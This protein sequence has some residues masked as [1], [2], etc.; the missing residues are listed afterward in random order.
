MAAGRPCQAGHPEEVQVGLVVAE[1]EDS[2]EVVEV[3]AE[4]VAAD[5]GKFVYEQLNRIFGAAVSTGS[6]F[7]KC[8]D[9]VLP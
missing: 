5:R 7:T 6:R 1:A 3:L 8:C 4:V 9:G 2:R